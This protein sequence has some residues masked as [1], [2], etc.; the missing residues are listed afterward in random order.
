MSIGES[1]L[2]IFNAFD[3]TVSVTIAGT[4]VDVPPF[5][6]RTTKIM[7]GDVHVTTTFLDGGLIEQFDEPERPFARVVYNVAAAAPLLLW[8]ERRLPHVLAAERW[9]TNTARTFSPFPTYE[10]SKNG[11]VSG[12]GNSGPRSWVAMIPIEAKI[13]RLIDLHGRLS[14]SDGADLETWLRLAARN[15]AVRDDRRGP[16][17]GRSAR[18]T[19]LY[20]EQQVTL[21]EPRSV[22]C[23]RHI[24]ASARQSRRRRLSVPRRQLHTGSDR[25]RRRLRRKLR[26]A[27]RQ[28]LARVRGRLRARAAR[29]LE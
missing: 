1:T 15:W 6:V 27:F 21:P 20:V 9:T 25:A 12:P 19:T 4:S 24:E 26:E 2:S 22:I 23:G 29:T 7:P 28:R 11:E 14:S 3:R 8:D 13:A 16:T 10:S 17:R 18:I 5:T